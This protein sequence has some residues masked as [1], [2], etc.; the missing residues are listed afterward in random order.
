MYSGSTINSH[1][2]VSEQSG[3]ARY[4]AAHCF[5][6]RVEGAAMMPDFP[7]GLI[8]I[9]DTTLEARPGDFVIVQ[10]PDGL[11]TFRQL[12]LRDTEYFLHAINPH[13][14]V[15][16]LADSFITGVVRETVRRLR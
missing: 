2:T 12:I 1:Q 7:E 10:T 13:Y 14:P 8:L 5:S 9:V 16:P 4:E 15:F 6:L 11:T 3:A